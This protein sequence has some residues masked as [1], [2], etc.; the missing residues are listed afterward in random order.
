MKR[1]KFIF[2]YLK[3]YLNAKSK[4]KIHSPFV[5]DLLINVI[6]YQEFEEEFEIIEEIRTILSENENYIDF[7][8]LGAGSNNK[9]VRRKIKDIVKDSSKSLKYSQL[10]YRIVKYFEPKTLIELGT[11]AG[12]STMYQALAANKT[13]LITIEGSENV[14]EIAKQNFKKL[15]LRNIEL[16]LDNFDNALPRILKGIDKLDY[17][18]FDGNHTKE[19]TLNYFEQ[20]LV[21]VQADTVFVVDDIHWSKEMEEAWVEIQNNSKVVITIDLFFLGLVFFIK[22]TVKQNHVIRF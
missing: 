12:I 9:T 3:Y 4:Y 17:V 18:F 14:A 10:L 8:D 11:S 5:Y 16:V 2:K 20:C 15:N 7:T 6:Y 21:K 22:N 1:L 13:K 19:A